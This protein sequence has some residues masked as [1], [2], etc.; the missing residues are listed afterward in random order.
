MVGPRVNLG[1]KE[2]KLTCEQFPNRVEN[3]RYVTF[4]L[5]RLLA[6]AR[7]LTAEEH[8]YADAAEES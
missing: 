5:E 8:T 6:E 3:K 4:L 2:L 1:R 7:R